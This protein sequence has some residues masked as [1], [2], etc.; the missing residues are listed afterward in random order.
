MLRARRLGVLA[1]AALATAA[2]L[3]LLRV[4]FLPLLV[5]GVIGY[6]LSGPVRW[7]EAHGH[8]RARATLLTFL[9][10]AFGLLLLG[11]AL[12][13]SIG[14]EA[15][16]LM[17]KLPEIGR[18][19]DQTL[20]QYD[21]RFTSSALPAPYGQA[22][23]AVLEGIERRAVGL[24]QGIVRSLLNSAPSFLSLLIAPWVAYFF[25]RDGRR[26]RHAVFSIVP[27]GWHEELREWLWRVDAV[28]AGFLRGQLIV[29]L[30]VAGLAWSVMTAF[31]LGY[32]VLVGL[33]AGLTDAVPLVGPFIGA[34]PAVLIA[35]T[36][37]M[38]TAAWVAF[39]FLLIHEAEGN[40]L[41]PLLVGEQMGIHPVT[42]VLALL[43]GGELGGFL[44]V[45]VA[46]PL[47]GILSATVQVLSR[48][49][50]RPRA[51]R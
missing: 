31:G 32:G 30:V 12:A 20:R 2:L 16:N 5:G 51:L 35:S 44:G 9:V 13:P 7:M 4:A 37:S 46:A 1:A 43:V 33:L 45:L 38:T 15:R 18:G 40:F 24:L 8:G 19:I 17:A 49:L 28:L 23:D 21:R 26:M 50:L 41:E 22:A 36:R 11:L 42:L 10:F 14:H 39:A 34:L 48:R 3:Y 47:A 29:A 6:L 25:V 27:I